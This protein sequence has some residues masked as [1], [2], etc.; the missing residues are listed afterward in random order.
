MRIFVGI[1]IAIILV[2]TTSSMAFSSSETSAKKGRIEWN[3]RPASATDKEGVHRLLQ[4]SYSALLPKDY[5]ED[6]LTKALPMITGA[7]P[8]L[9]TCP[10]WYVVEHPTTGEI[11][12]CGGWT[13][14]PPR[15]SG[16]PEN[17]SPH[18]RHFATDPAYTRQGIARAIWERT[19]KDISEMVGPT[20][21]LEVFST[22][23][24]ESF[25]AAVGF[26]PIERKE[27]PLR[28][29][30]MFPSILMKRTPR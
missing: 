5:D 17:E 19:W 13:R 21:T 8:Q 18:L 14:H 1:A 2:S 7:Q 24:A 26:V 20:T 11:V 28:E 4:T 30:C 10:T 23:T 16:R 15:S 22:L 12:G 9:L 27:I 6:V 25:Y 3:V 29:D